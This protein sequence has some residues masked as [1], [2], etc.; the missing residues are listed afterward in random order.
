M[1]SMFWAGGFVMVPVMLL[2]ALALGAGACHAL[3]PAK[4]WRQTAASLRTAVLLASA[5][6]VCMD[7]ATVA[8]Y[9]P[10]ASSMEVMA[11]HAAVGVSESLSPAVFG[12]VLAMLAALLSA[13]GDAR[14]P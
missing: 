14:Q 7:L 3:A 12:T 8:Q 6:G 4:A 1:F 13:V 5:A 9:L 11:Q 10:E 2:G